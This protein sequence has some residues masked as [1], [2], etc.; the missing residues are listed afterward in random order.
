MTP[1][2]GSKSGNAASDSTS[3]GR[4]EAVMWAA[5]RILLRFFANWW[6]SYVVPPQPCG[7]PD[8]VPNTNPSSRPMKT[9]Y[10]LC[11]SIA[12]TSKYMSA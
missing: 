8:H 12:T 1:R 6:T 4:I 9:P 5:E 3:A 2:E 7:G 11:S 10:V